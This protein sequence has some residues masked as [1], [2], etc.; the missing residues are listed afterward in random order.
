VERAAQLRLRVPGGVDV[1]LMDALVARGYAVYALDQRGYGGTPRDASGWLTPD[2]AS[3]RQRCARLVR[4]R[5]EK[6]NGSPR[7]RVAAR[8]P[9]LLGYSRGAQVAMLVAQRHPD[10]ISAWCCSAIRSGAGRA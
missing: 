5:E 8:K 4:A 10:Q 7:D 6:G 2:R 9:M 1:S 3:G